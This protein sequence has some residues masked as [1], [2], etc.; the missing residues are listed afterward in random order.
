MLETYHKK[1]SLRRKLANQTIAYLQSKQ[2]EIRKVFPKMYIL[3]DLDNSKK[4][5]YFSKKVKCE[6]L[7]FKQSKINEKQAPYKYMLIFNHVKR[8]RTD[9]KEKNFIYSQ[10]QKENE[11]K[12]V[13]NRRL[14]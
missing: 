11:Q 1:N 8:K 6:G 4:K 7:K 3:I 10:H 12:Q 14:N 13:S 9:H 5:Q 2:M